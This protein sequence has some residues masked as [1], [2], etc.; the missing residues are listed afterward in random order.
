MGSL[1]S[2]NS[3][4]DVRRIRQPLAADWDYLYDFI[5]TTVADARDIYLD[6]LEFDQLKREN[7]RLKHLN[8]V[9]LLKLG[10]Y[11]RSDY[12]GFPDEILLDIFRHSLPPS[13]LLHETRPMAPCSQDIPSV[14]LRIKLSI[15]RV[16]KSWNRVGTGLLYERVTLR[17]ITQLPVFVRALERREELRALV[18]HVDM[19]CFVPRGYSKLHEHETKRMLGLCPNL[20]HVGFSPQF[21]IPEL[22]HSIP[23][24]NSG[25]ITS[26]EYNSHIPYSNIHPSLD[27]P[28]LDFPRLEDLC[29]TITTDSVVSPLKWRASVR[30]LWV[31]G[32]GA[33]ELFDAYGRTILFLRIHSI[34]QQ[35]LDRCPVLEHIAVNSWAT[36]LTHPKIRFIDTFTVTVCQDLPFATVKL[37]SDTFPALSCCRNFDMT[38]SHFRYVPLSSRESGRKSRGKSSGAEDAVTTF[39]EF[40]DPTSV[41]GAAFIRNDTSGDYVPNP[42]EDEDDDS[43]GSEYVLGSDSDD[44]EGSDTSNSDA[45]SCLATSEDSWCSE[46]DYWEV[47][48]K[49]AL[50]IFDR[51]HENN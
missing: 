49:E 47:G 44:D 34:N 5:K 33:N 1:T 17:R 4:A 43:E 26:L 2:M 46:E 7:S 6:K 13:W 38:M 18:K 51:T 28:V 14:D 48:R 22:P 30:R 24:I 3:S 21:W 50:A 45:A 36:A 19:N 29:L 12:A 39:L 41:N 11:C 8:N 40:T 9:L 20:L 27:H 10:T 25:S 32:P 31:Y 35:V 37:S 42:D 23:T 15:L 16:C